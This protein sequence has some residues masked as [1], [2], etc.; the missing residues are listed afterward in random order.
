MKLS[1][2]SPGPVRFVAA[3][4]FEEFSYSKAAASVGRCR[5]LLFCGMVEVA[6]IGLFP[7]PLR[8]AQTSAENHCAGAPACFNPKSDVE[9]G[10]RWI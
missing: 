10:A 8:Q 7:A 3:N 1:Q 4:L 5:E 9:A 6:S 2:W